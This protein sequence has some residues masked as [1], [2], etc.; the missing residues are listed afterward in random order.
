MSH[1]LN[2][3]VTVRGESYPSVKAAAQALGITPASVSSYLGRRGHTDGLGLGA[4]SPHRNRTPHHRVPV[5]I[6]GCR[7]ETIKAAADALGVSYQS[8][9][10]TIRTG[11]TPRKSDRLLRLVMQWQARSI[12]RTGSCLMSDLPATVADL[13]ARLAAMPRIDSRAGGDLMDQHRRHR[14][15]AEQLGAYLTATYGARIST[16]PDASRITMH[17]ISSS[18]TSGL[19]SAFSNWIAAA[20]KRLKEAG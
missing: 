16:K 14:A 1:P 11:M 13:R 7:F 2:C 6:H 4:S 9:H 19:H 17:R 20:E 18:S 12:A 8:L 3:P 15:A 10:K 5:E